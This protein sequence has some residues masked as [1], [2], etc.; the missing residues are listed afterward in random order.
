M[1]GES[2]D[3]GSDPA[4]WEVFDEASDPQVGKAKLRGYTRRKE[5]QSCGAGPFGFWS[6]E[7][8]E[9]FGVG[10]RRRKKL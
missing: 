6:V 3:S 4:G 8:L 2:W 7:K 1:D 9:F 10:E 5:G